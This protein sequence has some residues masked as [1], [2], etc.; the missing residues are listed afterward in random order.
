MD[1]IHID[2]GDRFQLAKDEDGRPAIEV[3]NAAWV[4]SPRLIS[5]AGR[6]HDRAMQINELITA[7]NALAK[8]ES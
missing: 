5:F 6:G 8:E 7:L 1:G 2:F 4:E 3:Q